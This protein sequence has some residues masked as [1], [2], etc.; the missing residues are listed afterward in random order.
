MRTR[1]GEIEYRVDIMEIEGIYRGDVGEN[2]G[3]VWG[4]IGAASAHA[5]DSPLRPLLH[6]GLLLE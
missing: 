4:N 6:V 2:E 3:D 1:L 5:P